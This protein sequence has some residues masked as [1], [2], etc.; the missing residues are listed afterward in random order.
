MDGE[1]GESGNE[2]TEVE[3]VK[4]VTNDQRR[5]LYQQ[6]H[7]ME[8]GGTEFGKHSLKISAE[9]LQTLQEEKQT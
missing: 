4:Q 9:E 7:D 1:Q 3:E 2:T 8:G 5:Q 6:C